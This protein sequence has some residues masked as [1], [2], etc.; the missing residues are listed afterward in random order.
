MRHGKTPFIT[1]FLT[2]PVILY[3]A[4]VIGPYLQAFYIAL[5]DWRGVSAQANFVGLDNFAKIFQD[6]MFWKAIRNHGLL[7]LAVPLATI[8]IALTFSFLLNVAGGRNRSG[9]VRGLPG[10][11]FYRVVFFFP[12]VLSVVVIGV[13]FQSVF[14]PDEAGALNSLLGKV[15]ISPVGF[16]TEPSLALWAIIGVM[17]WSGVGFYVVLF[18]AGMASIPKELYEAAEIDGAGRLRVFLSI[19]VPLLRNTLQV[20]WVYLGIAALDF[21]ALIKV[22][23]M[24]HGGPDGAT[25][26]VGLQVWENAFEHYKFGYASALGVVLFFIVMTFAA[27]TMRVTKRDDIEY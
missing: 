13:L 21:F 10:S 23:A 20:A 9:T 7:L 25:T 12:Q 6:D 15:G 19:T 18:S 24:E 1:G 4:F 14:R 27:L 22:L 2:A 5:T 26:V 3:L 11:G 8:V 17:V 16:L